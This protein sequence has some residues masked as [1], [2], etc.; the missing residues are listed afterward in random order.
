MGLKAAATLPG[1]FTVFKT[2]LF[3][4][5]GWPDAHCGGQGGREFVAILLQLPAEFWD[6]RHA[7]GVYIL[8][9]KGSSEHP[10]LGVL[11][12][13]R[14]WHS[15]EPHS[16]SAGLGRAGHGTLAHLWRYAGRLPAAYVVTHTM[17][18]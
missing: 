16:S 9:G 5:P 4:D 3:W 12:C 8:T 15:E 7:C 14:G 13:Q 10:I 2:I 6:H 1:S 11:G 18:L 17:W